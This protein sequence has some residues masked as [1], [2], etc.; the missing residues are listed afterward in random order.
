MRPVAALVLALSLAVTLEACKSTPAADGRVKVTV[1]RRV[2]LLSLLWRLA[3][4]PEYGKSVPSPYRDVLDAHFAR[5]ADHPAVAATRALRARP[6]ISH[7]APISL[8]VY[9][10]DALR[11]TV[12]LSTAPAG[13]DAR[14]S[15]VP[16][17]ELHAYLDKVRAFA[18]DGGFDDLMRAQADYFAKVE[19][20]FR[21]FLADKPIVDWF[22]AALGARA[23]ATYTLIPGLLTGGWNYGVHAVRP[24]GGETIVQVMLLERVDGGGLPRPGVLTWG[25]L[26]HELAHT[27]VNP[28]ID[29]RWPALREAAEHAFDGVRAAMRDQ[30]YTS[31]KVVAQESVV[32]ALT[33]MYLEDK[34]G[35]AAARRSLD[36]Q[37]KLSFAWTE[38]LA[39]RLEAA[40][41]RG[42]GKLS[43]DELV[44][45]ARATFAAH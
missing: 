3:G 24:D 32:R 23:K 29:A 30:A 31:A 5:F 13:L 1:D 21:E 16:A 41:K 37:V 44:E 20:R 14:W 36:E 26:A 45:A 35:H 11:P 18:A 39:G 28:V 17:A 27:Y 10:D 8:A 43:D 7:N 12:D 19:Q 22:D 2:E 42:G 9:L 15:S 34:A 6:G 40:R 25:L 33:V 38:E 4:A